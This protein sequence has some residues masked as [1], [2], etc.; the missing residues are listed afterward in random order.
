MSDEL[1]LHRIGNP[2]PQRVAVSLHRM[3]F[4]VKELWRKR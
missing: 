4:L 2:D 1:G 3:Y